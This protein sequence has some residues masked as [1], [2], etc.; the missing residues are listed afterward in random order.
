MSVEILMPQLGLTM[1]EGEISAWLV[2]E[3]DVIKEGDIIGEITTDKLTNDLVAEVSGTVL[4]L[5]A[6]VG[7][8]IP[9]KGLLAIIG[10]AGEAVELP[11]APHAVKKVELAEPA[12]NRVPEAGQ[13]AQARTEGGRIRISPLARKI[14]GKHGLDISKIN[15]TGP[16]GRIVQRDVLKAVEEKGLEEAPAIFAPPVQDVADKPVKTVET[17]GLVALM[18]GDRIE[19]L[20]GMR[21]VVGQRMLQSTTEIPP[22][23][24]DIKADVSKLLAF[25]KQV[26]EGREDRISIND[27]IIKATAKALK[28]HPEINVSID[29]NNRIWRAHVN[30]G[31]A[32]ALDDGLLV[33]VIRDADMKSIEAISREAKDLAA[34]ARDNKLDQSEYQGSTFSISNIGMY[35]ISS[36]TPIINQPDAAILGVCAT[37]DVLALGENKDIIVKKMMTLSLTYD[38]RL[39]DGATAAKFQQ[40]LVSIIENPIDILL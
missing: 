10:E 24:Q 12:S 36:F 8:D 22:V 23:T 19:K 7:E 29:G 2:K 21:K 32:V 17:S 14:A 13:A 6:Q 33:P 39:I 15:G 20:S 1:E 16:M 9:V 35:G 27:F 34:R 30:I 26:N 28:K 37:E 11:E 3:G 31:M 38:H 18:E 4:K 5:V 40:T 25:R